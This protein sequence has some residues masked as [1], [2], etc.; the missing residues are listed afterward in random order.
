MSVAAPEAGPA[1]APAA[2]GSLARRVFGGTGAITAAGVVVR[3][4]AVLS[5]PLLTRALGP[6]P[7]GDAALAGTLTAL[8]ATVALLGVDLAYA[9]YYFGGLEANPTAVESF[10][11]RFALVSAVAV[12]AA[13]AAVWVLLIAPQSGSSRGLGVLVAAGGLLGVLAALA[14]T[15]ARL[16]GQYRRLAVALVVSGVTGTAA[17]LGMAWWWRRD[18]WPLLAGAALASAVLVAISGVPRAAEFLRPSGLSPRQRGLVVRL[19]LP[20]AGTALMYWVLSSADRFVIQAYLP[21]S[22]LGTYSFAVGLATA[23]LVLNSAIVTVWYPEASRS[24]EGDRVN[25][26]ALLG[27]LWSRLV[28]LL[29]VVWLAV[30]MAGGDLIRLLADPRFAGGAWYVPWLAGAVFFYGVASL[31]NTG[32]VLSGTMAPAALCWM[33]GIGVSALLNLTLVPRVGAIAAA[34]AMCTAFGVIA[35]GVM[36]TSERWLPL[37][38]RWRVLLPLLAAVLALGAAGSTPWMRDPA[39][40]LLLK[41][42]VGVAAA[43]LAVRMIAPDWF[44]RALERGAAALRGSAA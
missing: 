32:L 2:G 8:L 14:Q 21:R 42:P 24:Y 34:V 11:W 39:A 13:G 9:R 43:A 6:V 25:A 30:A 7:Y 40:S 3:L 38:I 36:W 1:A 16:R 23:G 10:C 4:V 15:R 41:L 28:V 33:V 37:R 29:A 35:A 19:G 12:S 17:T 44:Q 18:A 20:G 22:D 31:A 26:P 5:A 27:R